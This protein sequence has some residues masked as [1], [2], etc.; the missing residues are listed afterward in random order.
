MSKNHP[1]S[2]LNRFIF[3]VDYNLS[4]AGVLRTYYYVTCLTPIIYNSYVLMF[5]CI[6]PKRIGQTIFKGCRLILTMSVSFVVVFDSTSNYSS[7]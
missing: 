2:I 4:D 7:Q 3:D 6:M 5:E 1:L